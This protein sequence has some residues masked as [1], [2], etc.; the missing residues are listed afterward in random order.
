MVIGK[1]AKAIRP[2]QACKHIFGYTIAQDITARDWTKERN[3]GQYLLGKSMDMF[4][5]IGPAV[6]TKEIINDAQNLN[7]KSWVNGKLKQDGNTSDMIFKV[8]FLVSYLSQ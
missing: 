8:D 7:I 4:C 2:D 6:V 5:P 3:N 1:Q